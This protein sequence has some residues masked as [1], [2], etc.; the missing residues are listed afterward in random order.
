MSTPGAPPE[1][2]RAHRAGPP[3]RAPRLGPAAFGPGTHPSGPRRGLPGASSLGRAH[4]SR[5]PSMRPSA[6]TVPDP[7]PSGQGR[8]AAGWGPDPIGAR[9]S[10]PTMP[11]VPHRSRLKRVRTPAD[12]R[13]RPGHRDKAPGTGHSARRGGCAPPGVRGRSCRPCLGH[14]PRIAEADRIGR[15]PPGLGRS[16]ATARA[17]RQSPSPRSRVGAPLAPTSRPGRRVRWPS[18]AAVASGPGM[19]D[20]AFPTPPTASRPRAR[21]ALGAGGSPPPYRVVLDPFPDRTGIFLIC[22]R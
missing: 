10:V 3:D 19:G 13:F 5:V 15:Y 16:R 22:E 8:P 6:P 14:R 20:G 21:S 9:G 7:D 1:S 2:G 17:W 12:A 11:S 4:G 18:C